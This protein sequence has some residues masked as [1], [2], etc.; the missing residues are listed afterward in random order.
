MTVFAF[1]VPR[2]RTGLGRSFQSLG[3][4][5]SRIFTCLCLYEIIVSFG[6]GGVSTKGRSVN[7]E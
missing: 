2:T 3:R 4:F 7:I 1:F 6:V 5:F